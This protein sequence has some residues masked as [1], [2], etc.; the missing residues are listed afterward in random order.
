[1]KDKYWQAWTEVAIQSIQM[2]RSEGRRLMG[3]GVIETRELVEVLCFMEHLYKMEI[4][5]GRD[6]AIEWQ[7]SL[8]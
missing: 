7:L 4:S 8:G 1:M 2:D 5:Q 6:V 3:G